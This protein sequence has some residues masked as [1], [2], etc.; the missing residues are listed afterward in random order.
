MTGRRDDRP[1][2]GPLSPGG[3]GVIGAYPGSFNPPTHAHLAIVEAAR[4]AHGLDRVDL[5]VSRRALDKEDV[6]RPLLAHRLAV[7]E[8]VAS[9]RPWL[10]VAVTDH[11]LLV[12]IAAGYD[13]LVVG[14]DKWHQLRDAHYYGS[15]E[16]RDEALARLPRLAVA[17]RPP[18][19]TPP[20]ITLDLDPAHGAASSTAAREGAVELMLPEAARFDRETGA[21]TDPERYEHWLASGGT[22]SWG[23]EAGLDGASHGR[24]DSGAVPDGGHGRG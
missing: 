16:A 8:E 23:G 10:G 14:G 20:E 1:P 11:Q 21:W 22:T 15:E 18:W 9:T 2:A 17:P 6:V 12:D 13:V 4:A 5:V 3:S 24:A 19:D 7:L